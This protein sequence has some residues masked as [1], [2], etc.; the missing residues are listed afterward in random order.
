MKRLITDRGVRSVRAPARN[1]EASP[2][3]LKKEEK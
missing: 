3:G 1:S 2:L